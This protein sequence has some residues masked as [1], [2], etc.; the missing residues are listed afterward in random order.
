MNTA[1]QR[2]F[3]SLPRRYEL[4][5][6]VT[7]F[8]QDRVWR[9]RAAELAS[10]GARNLRGQP[11]GSLVWLDVSTGT[12]E[13]AE[14][15]CRAAGSGTSV[16]A[17]DFSL[18]ML[19][20]AARKKGAAPGSGGCAGNMLLVA[21]DDCRLPFGDASMDLVTISLGTRNLNTS[22]SAL[23]SCFQEFHRVLRPGG[24]FVNLETTQPRSRAV[25]LLFHGYVR[26]IVKPAASAIS[27]NRSAYSYLAST[28]CSFYDAEALAAMIREAGFGRVGVKRLLLGVAAIHV[29]ERT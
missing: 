28:I 17:V 8:G 24:R 3:S 16:L 26:G 25:R 4:V 10:S 9:A 18:P 19:R 2:M 15:L 22:R 7:T 6:H 21:A 12:G 23:L 29:A 14:L 20:W 1:I 11:S 27:G 13:M 5:N